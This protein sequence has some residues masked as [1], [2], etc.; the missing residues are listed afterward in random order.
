MKKLAFG[1]AA[2]VVLVASSFGQ[3]KFTEG[4]GAHTLYN[5][6]NSAYAGTGVFDVAFFFSAVNTTPTVAS[7]IATSSSTS[8]S[9]T[10]AQYATAWTDI[11]SD[12]NFIEGTNTTGVA[13][14][15]TSGA[16][17]VANNLGTYLQAN[18]SFNTAYYVYAVAWSSAYST[19]QAAQAAGAAVGWSNVIT[20]TTGAN[21]TANP[22]LSGAFSSFGVGVAPTPEPSTIAL[23]GLGISALVAFRRS[24]ASK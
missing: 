19:P 7:A 23:A 6:T 16:A 18:S 14:Q 3:G 9:Y 4:F 12:P 20:E 17:G 1:I 24:N 8:S 5:A 13:A 11:L 15:V 10:A 21:G 22:T 2:S